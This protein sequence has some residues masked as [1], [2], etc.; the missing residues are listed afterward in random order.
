[1]REGRPRSPM[2]GRTAVSEPTGDSTSVS[3][4]RATS[5]GCAAISATPRCRAW[6]IRPLARRC[7]TCS[8]VTGEDLGDVR[9]Q[10]TAMRHTSAAAVECSSAVRS[11]RASTVLQKE[12]HSRSFCT[13]STISVP[14]PAVNVPYD[15]T[16]AW[17]VPVR[18]GSDGNACGG[19]EQV[20]RLRLID[21]RPPDLDGENPCPDAED[22]PLALLRSVPTTRSGGVGR[23]GA[24]PAAGVPH[25]VT[26]PRHPTSA[27]CRKNRHITSVAL[28]SAV[29]LPSPS[30]K[31]AEDPGHV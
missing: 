28:T 11:A 29:T 3:R 15:A 14:S 6:A 12:A 19:N 7:S 2:A 25:P 13:E 8:P 26:S 16:A 22:A 17:L 27:C 24:G 1:M 18:A 21:A 9:L 10:C 30:G 4:F 20:V 31:T 5:W 23:R